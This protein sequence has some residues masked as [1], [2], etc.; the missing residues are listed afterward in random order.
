MAEAPVDVGLRL[1]EI[2]PLYNTQLEDFL[3][4]LY[5]G[6]CAIFVHPLVDP[7]VRE[8]AGRTLEA[9]ARS[10]PSFKFHAQLIFT[11]LLSVLQEG[12]EYLQDAAESCL[13]SLISLL[14]RDV[15]NFLPP[16]RAVCEA[17]YKDP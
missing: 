4:L 2:V 8:K 12:D 14:D 1:L 6:I 11:A 13:L 10:A 16:L 5:D 17:L 3:H 15:E 9:F 7:E